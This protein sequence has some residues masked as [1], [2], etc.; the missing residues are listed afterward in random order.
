MCFLLLSDIRVGSLPSVFVEF[1]GQQ[2]S[3]SYS[4]WFML[5][6]SLTESRITLEMAL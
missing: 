2:E 4:G 1:T 6:V 3:V 5:I